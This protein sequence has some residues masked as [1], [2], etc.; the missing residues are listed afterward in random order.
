[1]G[2]GDSNPAMIAADAG[3]DVWLG[4]MRGNMHSNKHMFLDKDQDQEAF[5]DF[6]IET[7]SSLD[8]PTMINYVRKETG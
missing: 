2:M 8:V 3:Y 6:D 4:N 7:V 5:F 1:M